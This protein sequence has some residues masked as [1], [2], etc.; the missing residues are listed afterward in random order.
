MRWAFIFVVYF[1]EG[2][3]VEGRESQSKQKQVIWSGRNQGGGGYSFRFVFL[4]PLAVRL[5]Y[6]WEGERRESDLD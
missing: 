6:S 2:S 1:A 3:K 5:T 4:R